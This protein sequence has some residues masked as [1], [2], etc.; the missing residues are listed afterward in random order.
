MPSTD[1]S[2]LGSDLGKRVKTD[3][4]LPR[5]LLDHVDRVC[6]AVGLPKNA[7]ISMGA[8]LLVVLL[9]PLVPGRRRKTIL[10]SA[11]KIFQTFIS[12]ARKS[13]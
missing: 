5:V 12:R 9:S 10:A 3:V 11:E 8:A 1:L 2:D 4:R 7:F 13:L 6:Q